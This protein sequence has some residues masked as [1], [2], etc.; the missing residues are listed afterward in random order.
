MAD[1]FLE[2]INLL[3]NGEL[4][5]AGNTNRAPS[6]INQNVR[7][8]RELFEDAMLG[9]TIF[10]RGRTVEADAKVG[11]PV[12]Y[13]GATQRY[14]RALAAVEVGD[15]GQF[16]TAPSA[17]AWGVI[18][19]KHN[20][21]SADILLHGAANV[22]FSESIVGTPTAGLYYLSNSVAGRLQKTR[23]PVG[24]TVLQLAGPVG[25]GTYACYV[26]TKFNDMLEAHRHFKF[27]LV[28]EP[29]GDHTPPGGG[30]RH[31]VTAGDADVEGWLPADHAVFDGKAPEGAAF[32]YNLSAS[33]LGSLW[34]PI[35]VD[36]AYLEL[37][38]GEA[39]DKLGM[40]VPLGVDQLCIIDANGIWWM[41]DCYGDVPW[42]TDYVAESLNEA[43]S[44]SI[45]CPRELA[46]TLTLWFSK[47][48]FSSS[49]T[50]VSSLQ[51]AAG[52]GLSLICPDNGEAATTGHLLLDFALELLV[53]ET[54]S[55]GHLALKGIADGKFLQGPVVES[56]SVT[57]DYATL[58][59]DV[60]A[61]DGKYYGNLNL[62]LDMSLEGRE[63]P[64]ESIRLIGA[65]E[66]KFED[67]FGIGFPASRDAA[68]RGLIRIPAGVTLAGG[69]QLKLRFW[70]LGRSSNSVPA[71]IFNVTYRRIGTPSTPVALPT[72]AAEVTL[73]DY[74]ADVVVVGGVN[75]YFVLETDS[76]TIAAGE[77]VLFTLTRAGATDGFNGDLHILRSRGVYVQS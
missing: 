16:Y 33:R 65:D 18:T 5:N 20:S 53:N 39:A 35:P 62:S 36:G 13:N 24:V 14:E 63:L 51:T 43:E 1:G 12:Y 8:L 9:E 2:L 22:D 34:P 32:G 15:D 50:W 29:A 72:S 46:M 3:R 73:G 38:R 47:P 52:S 45:E 67:T 40:G 70:V 27:D 57:G 44:I 69:T 37:N 31:V 19:L 26:N 7:R 71:D 17:Q 54:P 58:T 6:Q 21:T 60:A 41:S 76:F 77:D 4:V 68:I 10:A 23:P 74:P 56:L 61:V 55:A 48:V 30:Q 75:R 25:D 28:C 11:Q 59:S 66:E 49:G 42:P 64:V